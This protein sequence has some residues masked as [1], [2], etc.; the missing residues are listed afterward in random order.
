MKISLSL[1]LLFFAAYLHAQTHQIIK[2]NDEKINANFIKIENN[3]I[4]YTFPESSEEKKISKYAVAQLNDKSNKSHPIAS[5]KIDITK[6]ADY[7]KVIILRE[8]ETIG[9]K[10]SDTLRVFSPK[11]KG[12][13][14]LSIQEQGERRL[15]EKA[16]L[17]GNPFFVIVS[18]K[19][20]Y[21][22]AI[23]YTY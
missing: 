11:I 14:K 19:N 21:L 4:Y 15:K 5:Q 8:A 9:L 16:A 22:T 3:L 23:S 20:E 7:K 17:K 6:K 18:N 2:H 12:E 10:K 13:S 1:V